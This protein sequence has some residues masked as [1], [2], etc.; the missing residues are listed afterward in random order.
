MSDFGGT[1]LQN[2]K[3]HIQNQKPPQYFEQNITQKALK[4]VRFQG[5]CVSELYQIILYS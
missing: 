4:T 2:P 3:S 1:P 5:F